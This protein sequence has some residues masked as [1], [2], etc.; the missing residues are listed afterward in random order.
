MRT[1][2]RIPARRR[3]EIGRLPLL[4]IGPHFSSRGGFFLCLNFFLI[5]AYR[6]CFALTMFGKKI[7][8]DFTLEIE[9]KETKLNMTAIEKGSV[10]Y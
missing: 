8:K 3:N 6:A 4:T 9:D 7:D 5:V 1:G 2:V 10:E